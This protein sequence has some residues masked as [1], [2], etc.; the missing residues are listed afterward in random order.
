MDKSL[1]GNDDEK[2][3]APKKYVVSWLNGNIF[4]VIISN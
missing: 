2:V 4:L 3:M 1:N